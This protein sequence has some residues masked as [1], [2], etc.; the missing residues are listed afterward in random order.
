MISGLLTSTFA[1]RNKTDR[2]QQQKRPR[3]GGRDR[4]CL[5]I[6]MCLPVVPAA[7]APAP[8]PEGETC[9]PEDEDNRRR[10]PQEVER[11]TQPKKN[12]YQQQEQQKCNRLG[13]VPF[14]Y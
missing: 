10:D 3:H 9:Q 11:E 2:H 7:T 8:G 5:V 4:H 1:T 12:Q 13:R 14:P 6:K